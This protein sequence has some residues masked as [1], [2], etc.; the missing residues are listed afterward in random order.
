MKIFFSG[1][2]PRDIGGSAAV[3]RNRERSSRH[4]ISGLP[5][6]P[7]PQDSRLTAASPPRAPTSPPTQ[8]SRRDFCTQKTRHAAER[9]KWSASGATKKSGHAPDFFN[10]HENTP[11]TGKFSG[12]FRAI[13]VP[14][15]PAKRARAATPFLVPK[16]TV[17]WNEAESLTARGGSYHAGTW[18]PRGCYSALAAAWSGAPD[19][20]PDRRAAACRTCAAW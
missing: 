1:R 16:G 11:K 2:I 12:C 6:K 5:R 15:L 3:S 8:K 20:C 10:K 9:I 18:M 13:G 7:H 19:Q 4:K 14:A 17:L